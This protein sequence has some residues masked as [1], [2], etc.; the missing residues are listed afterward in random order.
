MATES[1]FVHRQ[2][3]SLPYRILGRV[4]GSFLLSFAA[5]GLFMVVLAG[6][7]AQ[8]DTGDG[9]WSGIIA[10][11]GVVIFA[12]NLVGYGMYKLLERLF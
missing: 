2:E 12:I 6:V 3:R 4:R 10:A 1:E 11:S 9:T 7:I 8:F 5:L